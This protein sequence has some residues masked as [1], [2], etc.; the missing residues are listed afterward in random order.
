MASKKTPNA[1]RPFREKKPGRNAAVRTAAGTAT[2]RSVPTPGKGFSR[3]KARRK[4]PAISEKLRARAEKLLTTTRREVAEMPLDDVQK[5][6]HELQVHRVELEMQNDELRRTHLELEAARERY[7]GLYDFA[8]SAH[9]TLGAEGEILEAN[10]AAGRLLGLERIRLIGRKFSR[11]VAPEAQDTFYLLCREVF[12]SDTRQSAELELVNAQAGRMFIQLEAVR[13]AAGRQKQFRIGLI[14]VTARK[15]AED[16]LREASQLNRQIIAGAKEGIIVYDRDLKYVVWN[17][18]MEELTG[19]PAAEVIGKPA[20]EIFPFLQGVG[21]MEQL[22]HVLAGEECSTKEFHFHVPESGRSG[23]ASDTNSPLRNAKGEITGVIGLVRD[24]TERK[25]AEERIAQ[26]NRVQ[27]ILGG[28]DRAIVHISERQKLMDE[29]CRVA[30]EKGGFK[31]AWIGMVSP[32]GSVQ[33]VAQAGAVEYLDGIRVLVTPDE[34]EGCGPVGTAIRQNWPVM[35]ENVDQDPRMNPWHDRAQRFGLHFVAA[36]PIRI[37]GKVA[38]AFQAYAPQAGFFDEDEMGLLTQVSDD[39]SFALTAIFGDAARREAETAL[40]LNEHHLTNFFNQAPIGMEWLS[41]G[42]VILRANQAQLDLLGYSAAEYL[43]HL[44]TDFC[45]EPASGLELLQRLAARETVRNFR[46]IRRCKDGTLR[47]VLVDAVAFWRENDFQYSSVFVRD[48][49]DRVKLEKEIIQVS[50]REH[51]RIAQDLHDGLGQLLAGTAH[52]T[53]TLQKDLAAKA[54]PEARRLN[55]IVKLLTESIAQTRQLARGLHPVEPEPNGLMVALKALAARTK[56]MFR[57]KCRFNCRRPV[58]IED[59]TVATHLFRIAQEAI[60]N[61]IKH[62][63]PRRIEISLT[64]TPQRIVLAVKNDGRGIPARHLKNQGLGLRI[65]QY[66]AGVIG[67]SLA[68]Q[69]EPDSET[70][71]VCS[72]HLLAGGGSHRTT[73]TG[74][75]N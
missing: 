31:L 68:I 20:L 38:G 32:D 62:G 7:A 65:M 67:G 24:I 73:A 60:T 66:R 29:I 28:V 58:L 70:A 18:F 4:L 56:T 42:G 43:K 23:W 11:F 5:L 19:I 36:F 48:I 15:R 33:P 45:A 10:L 69:K 55:R 57:V 52:M 46:M 63:Q 75:K 14:D 21:V 49:T 40:R 47:H 72:V 8:P 3:M 44:F 16:A 74:R 17:P 71:I 9:L 26:L 2:G 37:A 53:S 22:K 61:A 30:V 27:A 64:E 25:R 59:N 1:G 35:V 34:P 51:R 13:D 54:R 41:A 39:I 6:V 50:E 12:K